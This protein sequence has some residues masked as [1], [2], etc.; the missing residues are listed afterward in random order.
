M[1]LSTITT[2]Q[3]RNITS[4]KITLAPGVNVIRGKNGQGKTNFLEAIH[5][6]SL[7]KSFRTSES[8]ELVAWGKDEWSVFGEIVERYGS[9]QLGV[10][11]SHEGKKLYLQGQPI[12]AAQEYLGRFLTVTFSPASLELIQGAPSVRRKFLD[13][14]LA[15]ITPS[16][17][18][19]LFTYQKALQNKNRL[20]KE[21]KGTPQDIDPWNE[22][23]AR[24]GAEIIRGREN[25]VHNL[26]QQVQEIHRTFGAGDGVLELSVKSSLGEAG[27]NYE[28]FL[29]H[30]T[31]NREREVGYRGALYGPHRDDLIMTL[32]G[33][34]VRTHASQGQTRSIVLSLLLGVLTL[35][36]KEREDSPVVLL[37]D[38]N[39]ELDEKRSDQFF[40]YLN[41]SKRQIII[42]GTDVSVGHLTE[43]SGFTMFEVVSGAIST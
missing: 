12:K 34:D 27:K 15:D 13:R 5:V 14:Y 35:L 28:T 36:E 1:H 38:V 24:Q 8:D 21:G 4:G 22:L 30:L 43:R 25:F 10:S 23:L 11:Q 7:T 20:L 19:P 33:R 32:N 6:L 39:S 26:S 2:Y 42:T 16:I 29:N 3:W 40:S 31:K 37:D 41:N 18:N 17:L 9:F